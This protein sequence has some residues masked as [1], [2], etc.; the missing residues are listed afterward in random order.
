MSKPK[1]IWQVLKNYAGANRLGR[2]RRVGDRAALEHFLDSRSS[3]VAQM[4]LYGYLRTR[5]GTR[6]YELFDDAAFHASM[7]IAKWQIWLAC[8][9]DLSV[10]AGGLVA[11][12]AGTK[13]LAVAGA[14][15]GAQDVK[16]LVQ[17]LVDGILER[18]GV[19]ADAGEDF[20]PASQALRER[21]AACDLQVVADD[22]SAFCHSP[23]A[24][25][26]WAP[27]VDD[28]KSLDEEIVKN[29]IRFRWQ[30]VRRDLRRNL[31]ADALMASL[32]ERT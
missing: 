9:S 19:P 13:G 12:R 31:D 24:L 17:S 22:E 8:L 4:S 20:A 29:S 28:L 26:Y 27:V 16:T 2:R 25:V 11:Q 30:E 6:Y 23:E 7:N 5:A 32:H 18:T 15:S 14:G 10:Y 21:L 3:H 1:A